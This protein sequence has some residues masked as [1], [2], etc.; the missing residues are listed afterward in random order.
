MEWVVLP[1]ALLVGLAPLCAV[2][3]LLVTLNFFEHISGPVLLH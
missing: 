1:D 2:T 3:A